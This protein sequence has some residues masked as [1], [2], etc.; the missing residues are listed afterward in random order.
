M[1]GLDE[2]TVD[3]VTRHANDPHRGVGFADLRD[4]AGW[5]DSWLRDRALPLWWDV[6]AD[7]VRGGFHEELGPDGEPRPGARRARVQSRQAVVYGSAGLL[8]WDGPWREAAWHAMD[9]FLL[10]FRRNDGLFRCLVGLDGEILDD[11]AMLYDQGFALLASATLHAADPGRDDM[12]AVARGVRQGLETMRHPAGGYREN[13]AH[14]FQANA[15]MHLLEGAMAWAELVGGEW[16]AMVDEM[17]ELALGIFIDPEGRF[18]REFFDADWRAEQGDLGQ[19]VEPGHQ[20]E[21]AW[22]LSR[23]AKR[24][25]DGRVGEMAGHLYAA[26][27]RGVDRKRGV[28]INEV[29]GDFTV[30]DPVARLWPQTERLKAALL[31]DGEAEVLEAAD[32]LRTYLDAGYPG[33]W[34]D[35]LR[36]DGSFIEEHAP[37]TSFYHVLGAC[38]GLFAAVGR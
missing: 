24:R 38:Q 25:G 30:R 8:G 11:T 17:V 34:L 6:G 23:H 37:A 36:A 20:F 21:W 33:A 22:L 3:S 32:A 2:L 26:G 35:K 19:V 12:I 13:I 14:P 1:M 29:A 7:R 10:K 4:A 15:H 31:F 5:Y 16:E 9:F 27:R 28:A 18:V